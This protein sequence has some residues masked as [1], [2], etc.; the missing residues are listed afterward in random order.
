MKRLVFL[1]F[2]AASSPTSADGEEIYVKQ[3]SWAATMTTTRQ[4]LAQTAVKLDRNAVY[5][6]LYRKFWD[7]FSE[8][9]WFMQDNPQRPK[10]VNDFNA[11]RDFGWYF[12]SD[13]DTKPEQ[14]MIGR[15][16]DEI[17]SAGAIL[18][19]KLGA[20]VKAD[21]PVDSPAWLDLYVRACS[22]RRQQRLKPLLE[23]APQIV[24][25]KHYTLG[26][27]HYAY[28]EGQSDAQAERHFRPGSALCLLQWNG[29]A[30]RVETLIDDPTG[31]IRDP[32][33]SYDGRRVLFAWKKSD[34]EDDYHL[35]EMDMATHAVRQLTDGLGVADYEAAYL[36]DG[37]IIFNSSR[38][39]QIVDCWW[40]EVSNLYRCDRNGEFLR[41]LNFDQVHDNYPTVT[42]DGRILFTR[43]EYN[44]RGQVYPQPLLQ[45]NPDGTNQAEFYGVNSWFPTTILHA[46]GVPGTQ[47]ALAIATGHHSRQ[48]G[49]LI[50]ID[51]SKGRQENAGVQ[52][53]APVR[54]TPAVKI[55]AFGQGG[56]LFQYPYPLSETEYLVTYHPVGWQWKAGSL[57][58]RFGIYFMTIDGRR[59]LLASDPR[60]PCGQPVPLRAREAYHSRPSLVDYRQTHGTCYVQDVHAGPGLTGVPRGTIKT[61]RVVALDFRAA[62]IGS[63]GNGGPGGGALVS[64]PVAIG[65]GAWDPKIVLG[66]ATVEE[67]GSAF[68]SLPARMPVY[69]QLLDEKG[70][71]VQTMRSWT[72][73]QPGEDA[74]CVGCH[75]HKNS[76]PVADLPLKTALHSGPEKLKPFYGEPHG[77]SFPQVIQP[78]LDRH[79]VRCHNG[80]DDTPYDLTDREI[81]DPR[82]KRR[83]SSAY[84]ALTHSR[85][86]DASKNSDWRGNADHSMV[87]WVSAQSA[88]PMLPPYSAGSC[89]SRLIELL[90][91][92]HED[93]KLSREES[94][95][96]AAWI[97]LGV[98]YCADYT[99]ANTWTPAEI[100]KYKRYYAKRTQLAAEDQA[101][102]AAWLRQLSR[103]SANR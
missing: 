88:P 42:D 19:A 72:T 87:N 55:D 44:D 23:Q 58:P 76:T 25:T 9:D 2:V 13:R 82:A 31:V 61:L 98:P 85:P 28:T 10:A 74:S 102:I 94:E 49:K 62:G 6:D 26:G 21:T 60:L 12:E 71:L 41:R 101:N 103:E 96:I 45:M 65:N 69:F 4:H 53:V 86:N 91:S 37:D 75:E 20:L 63:N 30:F 68:F 81:K 32:D 50:L 34:R 56:E 93:V 99:E 43:W 18:A 83:W 46:R 54:E 39:V 84:L 33:V 89:R 97:D 66:D 11:R 90:D 5:A 3:A 27:S 70:R 38:C 8:T 22:Q 40:T 57:G 36:P 29:D 24:F 78:I 79:C 52:L 15:V 73:I 7:D 77:F 80:E 47:K 59:E 14:Q 95:K 67:D 17:G 51:P 100:E 16:L 48:T 92:G 35:Y 1:L 64:T